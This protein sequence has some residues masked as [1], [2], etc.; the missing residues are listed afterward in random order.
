MQKNIAAFHGDPSRVTLAG[1]SSGADLIKTLFTV[2]QADN[3]F[4][5]A[6]LQS[7]P[8][9]Y[10]DHAPAIAEAVGSIFLQ[11]FNCTTL[12]CL[13][14]LPLP[15][16]LT[17]QSTVFQQAPSLIPGVAPSEPIRPVVDGSLVTQSFFDA[18]NAGS[19]TNKAREV[20]F[21]TVLNEAGPTIASISKGQPIAQNDFGAYV[22]AL[23]DGRSATVLES[24]LYSPDANDP[25]GARVALERLGT[26]WIWR[27]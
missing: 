21:T 11:Q 17:A 20:V 3:L 9:N 10:G 24:G 7:S 15:N 13:Q 22:Q 2:P 4:R 26:D 18:I 5:R 6:I 1:Q 25:D 8:L 19:I 27:W 23:M 16:L 12:A 14:A